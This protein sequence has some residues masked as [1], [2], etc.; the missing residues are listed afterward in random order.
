[1]M[2]LVKYLGLKIWEN[3]VYTK[4]IQIFLMA[5]MWIIIILFTLRNKQY[6]FEETL[7]GAFVFESLV[8][9]LF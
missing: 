7:L 6:I 8:C 4:Y 2:G 9:K 3:R 5:L 1:M